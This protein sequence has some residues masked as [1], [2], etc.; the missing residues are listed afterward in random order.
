MTEVTL[1]HG[2][3]DF[4]GL[5]EDRKLLATTSVHRSLDNIPLPRQNAWA[6]MR[7]TSL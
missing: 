1:G 4:L 3:S 5:W 7:F 2:Q 6:A